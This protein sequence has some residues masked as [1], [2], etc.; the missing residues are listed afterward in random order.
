MKHGFIKVACASP[1]I[2]VANPEKNAENIIEF[3]RRADLAGV[4]LCAF[5]ELC[6][7]GYTC[8]DLFLSDR[9]I[10][11][12][13]A[14][15]IRL[16][17]AS[18]GLYPIFVV[19]LPLRIQHKL[20][21]CAAVI[22]NGHVLA[23][24][25]KQHLP[26][27]GEFYEMRHFAQPPQA[28]GLLATVTLDGESIPLCIGAVFAHDALDAYRFGIEIC[29]D[30]WAPDPPSRR[31]CAMGATIIL[32]PSAS[33]EAVGKSEYRRML[34][35]ATSARYLCGYVYVNAGCT[36]STQDVVFSSHNLISENGT[37]LAEAR[38]FATPDLLITDI[39]VNYLS[40]ERQRM[41]TFTSESP[42]VTLPFSQSIHTT[43]LTR[44]ISPAPFGSGSDAAMARRCETILDIQA[45]GLKKRIEHTH[46]W[47][48]VVGISGGL[49]S[50]LALLVMVRAMDM[51]GRNRSDIHA[52]SMPCFGT[53]ARTKDNASEMCRQL[54]VHF[55]EIFIADSVRQHF[56][57]IGHDESVRDVTYENSQARERTQLLMDYA[58][59][60]GALVIGTG[61]LSELAL[62]WA[63]YNGDHMSMYGVNAS[64]PKT[65]VRRVVAHVAD[66]SPAALGDVLRDILDTPVSPE[67]LPAES[68]GSIKQKT[69][70]IV[71]PYKLHDFFLYYTVRCGFAPDKIRRLAIRAFDG[72]YDEATI[73]RWLNTFIRRFF[74]QQ[75]KRSCLPD[76]P[77]VGSVSLSPR[78]DWR[79]PSD[80]SYAAFLDDIQA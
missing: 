54:G 18:R 66:R 15:L 28:Q 14:Q 68:D 25:P 76:G 52:I 16:R 31:L 35:S 40:S 69:E 47:K 80:A 58:N 5:P 33:T 73:D 61:D 75:F 41:N 26:N 78:G 32:N 8:G 3:M 42:A 49:D 60:I 34:I 22:Q 11:S 43:P 36:E 71:G 67:L 59:Q 53:T 37:L 38:P 39:D 9:L 12:A 63:T 24:V 55:Q 48:L 77:K 29:E 70:D 65:L 51:L 64:I 27:Y 2:V 1:E 30:L 57:D 19:G 45:H 10:N 46:T 74:T 13:R 7:T 44:K 50:C 23:L 4:N 21:N 79:M 72:I 56:K 20:Y 62:G 6:L 17:D